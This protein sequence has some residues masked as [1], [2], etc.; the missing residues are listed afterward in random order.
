MPL[1]SSVAR[2]PRPRRPPRWRPTP[3]A[4]RLGFECSPTSAPSSMPHER[5]PPLVP[6]LAGPPHVSSRLRRRL[7]F[8]RDHRVRAP[9]RPALPPPSAPR[10]C[11]WSPMSALR[12]ARRHPRTPEAVPPLVAR[13]R[14][15]C[16]PPTPTCLRL[17]TPVP[18]PSSKG[19]QRTSHTLA[20]P[21][22]RGGGR[23]AAAPSHRRLLVVGGREAATPSCRSLDANQEAA[24]PSDRRSPPRLDRR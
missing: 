18:R 7:L 17:Q 12:V 11:R 20:Q 24:A 14:R 22:C 2:P 16:Y 21:P 3:P 10:S 23:E 19:Q 15:A 8:L 9:A 4:T 5:E 6:F 1:S 13:T